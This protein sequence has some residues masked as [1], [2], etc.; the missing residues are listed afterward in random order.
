MNNKLLDIQDI[1]FKQLKEF[2]ENDMSAEKLSL[3]IS[4]ANAISNVAITF[5]KTINLN[6]RVKEMAEKYSIT[7]EQ[8][9]KELGL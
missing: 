5:I 4:K 9:K 2:E 3:E 1:L 8:I 6:I 7:E